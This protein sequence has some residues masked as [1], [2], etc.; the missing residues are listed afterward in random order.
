VATDSAT[1]KLDLTFRDMN[2]EW[3]LG[4]TITVLNI[5]SI[6]PRVLVLA[7]TSPDRKTK[8]SACEW[9]HSCTVYLVGKSAYRL[10][11]EK[12]VR[13][14][15]IDWQ[16]PYHRVFLRLI[17]VLIRLGVDLDTVTRDLF[18]RLVLQ[19]IHWC[20]ISYLLNLGGPGI[21]NM[22]IQRPWSCWSLYWRLLLQKMAQ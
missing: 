6:L 7:E 22:N 12:Q 4:K 14:S 5:E 21:H 3:S 20:V 8:M 15:F 16:S 17:P 13:I 19:C 9:L 1:F 11:H 18:R 10:D 2:I